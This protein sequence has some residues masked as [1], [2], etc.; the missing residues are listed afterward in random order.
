LFNSASQDLS[1]K[2]FISDF[3]D[4]EI[5]TI[6]ILGFSKIQT[7]ITPEPLDIVKFCYGHSPRIDPGND[8]IGQR[9]SS[10]FKCVLTVNFSK[11]NPEHVL[12]AVFRMYVGITFLS[13]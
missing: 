10:D 7:P 11:K 12:F 1:N 2:I 6:G 5:F 13:Y 3:D 9:R 4:L 8:S